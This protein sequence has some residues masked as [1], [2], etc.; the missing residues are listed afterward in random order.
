MSWLDNPVA[1]MP[2]PQFLVFYAVVIAVTLGALW[3][4]LRR[5]PTVGEAA[6]LVPTIHS[7][8]SYVV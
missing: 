7:V 4:L 5:D 2:G 8:C 3:A 6:P 1:N